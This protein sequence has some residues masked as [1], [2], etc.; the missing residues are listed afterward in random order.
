MRMA[1]CHPDR[2]HVAKGV[3]RQCYNAARRIKPEV[4]ARRR[5]YQAAYNAKPEVKARMKTY[6]AVYRTRPE[7]KVRTREHHWRRQGIVD[8]TVERYDQ[9]FISQGGICFFCGASPKTRRLNVDHDHTTGKARALLCARCNHGFL[10]L[11]EKVGLEQLAEYL[12]QTSL[13]K[14]GGADTDIRGI[15]E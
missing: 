9:M 7:N 1:E 10:P 2:K 15:S 5:A 3:C 4:K 14:A 8:M 12:G 6:G 13:Q 11:I